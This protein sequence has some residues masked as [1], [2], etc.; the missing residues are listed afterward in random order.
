[1]RHITFCSIEGKTRAALAMRYAC[2]GNKAALGFLVFF[3]AV[4]DDRLA[5][6]WAL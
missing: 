1:M 4:V 2:R 6:R 3:Q 5:W